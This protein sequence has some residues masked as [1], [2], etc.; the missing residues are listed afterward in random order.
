V[1]KVPP[2]K[3]LGAAHGC[4]LALA[5]SAPESIFPGLIAR[6][7]PNFLD[8]AAVNPHQVDAIHRQFAAL[9]LC[10]KM[11]AGR[12]HVVIGHKAM[13]LA[14]MKGVATQL[15]ELPKVCEKLH[16][17]DVDAGQMTV[18]RLVPDY[19]IGKQLADL[20]HL[21][22]TQAIDVTPNDSD[23]CFVAHVLFLCHDY[24]KIHARRVQR[25]FVS[26]KVA[27]WLRWMKRPKASLAAKKSP[28]STRLQQG[29]IPLSLA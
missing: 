17:A 7:Q 4:A 20:L 25:L 23:V 12:D 13:D 26:D 8:L 28:K 6:K 11:Q 15:H 3:A 14:D 19:V 22:P 21:A 16:F 18:T 24:R 1:R 27:V 5:G 10:F 2:A 29:S 9:T